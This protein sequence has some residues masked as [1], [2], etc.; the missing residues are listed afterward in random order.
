MVALSFPAWAEDG[1]GKPLLVVRFQ[2]PVV[3][4]EMPLY[5]AMSKALEANPNMMFDVVAVSPEGTDHVNNSQLIESSRRYGLQV[6]G[7]MKKM[8]M[9]EERIRLS[10]Q[11]SPYVSTS[12]VHLFV[13]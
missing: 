12:E 9:P 1:R 3:H 11:T 4:Y 13:Y 8:G 6:A 7:S 2:Q 10:S 5:T